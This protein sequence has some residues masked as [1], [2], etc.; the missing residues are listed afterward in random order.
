M[1]FLFAFMSICHVNFGIR[2]MYVN[3]L[4]S[5]FNYISHQP[6]SRKPLKQLYHIQNGYVMPIAATTAI[7][8]STEAPSSEEDDDQELFVDPKED[9]E[10]N[11]FDM[12][13]ITVTSEISH[14]TRHQLLKR[15]SEC[16]PP[17]F[18]LD[19]VVDL[20][21]SG[22]NSIVDDEVTKRFASVDELNVWNLLTRTSHRNTV[23][24]TLAWTVWVIGFLVRYLLLFPCRLAIFINGLLYSSLYAIIMKL[25]F[26]S[27]TKFK[28]KLKCWMG[29]L[30]FRMTSEVL[31]AVITIHNPENK[32][33]PGSI[34][35]ANHTSPIDVV[36]LSTED[37]YALTGQRQTGFFGFIEDVLSSTGDT[38]WF[39]RSKSDDRINVLKS[40]H[41]Y[42]SSKSDKLPVLLFPEGT[43]IN[44][45]S[46]MMFRK[47][48]FEIDVPVYPVAIK[49]DQRLGDPFWNSHRQGFFHYFLMMM[50]SWAIV[51]DV[52][53]LPKMERM[54]AESAID[55]AKRVKSAI[56]N[57]GGFVNMEWDGMLK[58]SY[59]KVELKEREQLKLS[60]RL[61]TE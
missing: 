59:P 10:N 5:I 23:T 19:E 24:S 32:A 15:I 49:Y 31:S 6:H 18:A 14:C 1:S 37:S 11:A 17:Y 61:K 41:E 34:C 57:V 50:T 55:F 35:V 4:I 38:I 54:P 13:G 3:C 52:Y 20:A 29:M 48:S 45:T 28:H 12:N 25:Y 42:V 33:K 60:Q 53:Y 39:D 30:M 8:M 46:V 56:A 58:R 26:N 2:Q 27:E 47:G 44:N 40:I 43:C 51:V 16:T 9:I 22:I 36:I 21:R 7:T